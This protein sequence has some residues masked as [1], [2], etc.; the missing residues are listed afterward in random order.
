MDRN[1]LDV[2]DPATRARL[3]AY[4]WVDQRERSARLEAALDLAAAD[5]PPIDQADAAD[6]LETKLSTAP[7]AGVCRV[8]MHTIAYQYFPPEGRLAFA[9]VSPQRALG[10]QR[11]RLWPG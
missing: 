6:W 4:V 2:R 9:P 10:R 5:P 7:E 1:P 11:T 3:A 8:V